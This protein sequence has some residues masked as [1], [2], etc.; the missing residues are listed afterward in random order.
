M[1]NLSNSQVN[2]INTRNPVDSAPLRQNFANIKAAINDNYSRINNNL[3]PGGSEVV[4]G[5]DNFSAIQGNIR[6]RKQ[7]GDRV[8]GFTDLQVV[9]NSGGADDTV[10]VLTGDGI[11]DGVGV[12]IS[13]VQTSGSITAASAGNH[14][15]IVVVIASDNTISA[16]S[17]SEVVTSS[18]APYPAI[19]DSEL[20]L[21]SFI[22]DET[23]PVV[24]NDSD[25]TDERLPAID[26]FDGIEYF[27]GSVTYDGS[28]RID[29]I[30]YT[31]KKGNEIVF[32][33][34]YTSDNLTEIEV[35]YLSITITNTIT[36]SNNNVSSQS[37]ALGV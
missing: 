6:A 27:G 5:R 10:Q 2:V 12:S 30:T 37:I 32:A 21:A 22:I 20:P 11:V 8:N 25:I 4:D 9:E 16:K 31:D 14:K 13:S 34:T 17:G 24:I 19:A 35:T 3:E 36:Y 28:N 7:Y 26:P 15:R 33:H 29:E 1:S 18:T 23:S